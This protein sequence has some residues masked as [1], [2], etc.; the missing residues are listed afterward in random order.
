MTLGLFECQAFQINFFHVFFETMIHI[1]C[2][3]CVE[4]VKNHLH[5]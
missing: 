5:L 2:Q 4:K 3:I 1:V